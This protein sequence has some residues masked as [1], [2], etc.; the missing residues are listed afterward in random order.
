MY[1]IILLRRYEIFK[2]GTD[3]YFNSMS[4]IVQGLICINIRSIMNIENP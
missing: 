3:F 2:N 1:R 4:I